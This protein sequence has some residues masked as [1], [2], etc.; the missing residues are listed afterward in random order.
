MPLRVECH[1]MPLRGRQAPQEQPP[2]SNLVKRYANWNACYT[3]GF[4][5]PDGHT[6]MLC[7]AQRKAGHDVYFARQNAQQYIDAGRN[8]CT[9][10][11]HKTQFPAM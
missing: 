6:S 10:F 8:C 11:R 5:V 9:R 4:N 3:C 2:Y 1:D 7:Q